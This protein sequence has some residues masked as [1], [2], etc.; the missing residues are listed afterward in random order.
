MKLRGHPHLPEEIEVVVAR[1]AVRPQPHIDPAAQHLRHG[2]NA[3]AKLHVALRVMRHLDPACREEIE[4]LTVQPDAVRGNGI[5]IQEIQIV[6]MLNRLLA[7]TLPDQADFL[8]GLRQ[9]DLKGDPGAA[10][11]VLDGTQGVRRAGIGGMTDQ[12]R[13]NEGRAVVPSLHEPFRNSGL[14]GMSG[15]VGRRE[16]DKPLGDDAAHPRRDRRPADL[17]FEK[18]PVAEGRG[19]GEDHFGD[20]QHCAGIHGPAVDE[21]CLGGKDVA[22]E[23]GHQRKVVGQTPE[24][25]HRKV[26]VDVHQSRHH[27][28]ARG[29]DDLAGRSVMTG[30]NFP[31]FDEVDLSVTDPDDRILDD[32]LGWRH[33]QKRPAGDQ[34]VGCFFQTAHRNIG[35]RRMWHVCTN[36]GKF[37]SKDR[38]GTGL[39][40]RLFQYRSSHRNAVGNEILDT[41]FRKAY[42]FPAS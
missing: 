3:R 6:E 16:I 21:P 25:G 1:T 10:R 36:C 19:S 18:I 41:D 34:D 26:G 28:A 38:G 15:L 37:P 32:L 12:G 35:L 29:V 20:G 11:H 39:Q 7:V 13:R 4:F 22:V 8:L 24:A 23:P 30:R 40:E 9:M 27:D 17:P 31:L 2:G 14:F 5:L 42:R 33:R